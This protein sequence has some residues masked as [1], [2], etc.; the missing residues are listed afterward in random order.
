MSEDYPKRLKIFQKVADK[1]TSVP[2]LNPMMES[3]EPIKQEEVQMYHAIKR[4]SS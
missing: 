1:W 2:D 3:E 4:P